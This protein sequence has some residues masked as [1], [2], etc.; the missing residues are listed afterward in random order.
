[1]YSEEADDEPPLDEC[2]RSWT[3]NYFTLDQ[4][5][6]LLE[7]CDK[8]CSDCTDEQRLDCLLEQKEVIYSIANIFKQFLA[9][10]ITGQLN[11]FMIQEEEEE[12][13]REGLYG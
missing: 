4:C 12:G 2:K 11:V 8:S 3:E 9:S 13:P 5:I 10:L 7:N 1:M 6:T